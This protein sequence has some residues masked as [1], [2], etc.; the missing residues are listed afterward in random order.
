V[1]PAAVSP[2]VVTTAAASLASVTKVTLAGTVNTN[3]LTATAWFEWGNDATLS[4]Y[5]STTA[6]Q[7]SAN[8]TAVPVS[9]QLQ[10]AFAPE[11]SYYYR[12]V[13]ATDAG[14]TRGD[15]LRFRVLRQ[16]DEPHGIHR[17]HKR[18]AQ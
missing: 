4:T 7:V 1:T 5:A 17:Q 16:P 3:G 15:I 10:S 2:P 6:V 12:V 13:A 11:I 18:A 8:V 14:T 9:V